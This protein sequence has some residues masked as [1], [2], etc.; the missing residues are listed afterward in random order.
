MIRSVLSV[1]LL[2]LAMAASAGAQ[3]S[4]VSRRSDAEEQSDVWRAVSNYKGWP[5]SDV[6]VTGVEKGRVKQLTK[7]LYLARD[8]LLYQSRLREDID[9]ILLF[10]AKRGYP[11]AR[12]TP[13]V[14]PHE[15]KREITL[16]LAIDQGPPVVIRSCDLENIP[17]DYFA[18]IRR[19]LGLKPGD[20]FVDVQL[21]SDIET[22]TEELKKEGYAHAEVVAAF[23]WFDSTAVGIRIVAAPGPVC[24][25]REVTVQGV[26]EDLVVLAYTLV[27]I[28]RG[29]RYEPRTE[30]EARDFLS[31]TGLFRQIRLRT[32]PSAVD[33]LDVIVD[34]QER[35][36]RSIETAV[37]Y[38]SDERFTGRIRWQHR[39]IFRR[40][41]G[42]SVELVYNQFRQWGEWKT[43]WPAL[44]GMKK[45]IGTFRLGLD[46]RNEEN[47]ELLAPTVGVSYGYNFTRR[48]SGTLSAALS[49]ASYDIKSEEAEFFEDPTGPVGWFEGR[50]TRDGTNDRIEPTSGSFEWARFEWGP[51]GGVSESNWI[52]AEV[53]GSYLFPL[54]STVFAVNTRLGWAAPIEPSTILLPDRRFYA[55]GSVAMRGFNRRK[56]GPKDSN[57]I[58]IGGEV[59]A[60][61]FFEYRFPIVWKI[62]GAVFFDWGQVWQTREDVTAKNIELAIGP[63]IRV[64]TPVGPLRLDWGIRLT[65]Y[66]ETQSKSA[67][68]FA[69]GYPM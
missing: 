33:S 15:T 47:Y 17:G 5:V 57:G 62:N 63:A 43:W 66:D 4:G 19:T 58:G 8:G 27:D 6:V 28:R 64:M 2:A 9:R 10:L 60:L 42:T 49:R 59:L 11:Y 61:G 30:R 32:E 45:S 38:W 46:S 56:L 52:L 35:K 18:R 48:F 34:L 12:V 21:K 40:G 3:S 68:H 24:Y 41:R 39:N 50:L 14:E 36:P 55:G 69:I 65:D 37:G 53:N 16:A 1:L 20:I 67:F 7:G 54:K 13:T 31:R 23:E 44:F 51:R 25:F 29:E 22:V 26:S